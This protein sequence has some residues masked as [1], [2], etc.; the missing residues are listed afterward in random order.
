MGRGGVKPEGL[1]VGREEGGKISSIGEGC[2][3]WT[4]C[5]FQQK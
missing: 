5:L 2:P 4:G 3:Q 1:G